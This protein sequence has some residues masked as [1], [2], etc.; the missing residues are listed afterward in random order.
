MTSILTSEG[1]NTLWIGRPSQLNNT[2]FYLVM[3]GLTLLSGGL[4]IP[5]TVPW[6]VYRIFATNNTRYL[7]TDQRLFEERGVFSKHHDDL[8]LY[9]VRDSKVTRPFLNRFFGLSTVEVAT[10][11]LSSPMVRLRGIKDG[12][13]FREMLRVHT[14]RMREKR[15]VRDIDFS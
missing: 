1:E 10:V 13:E 3:G 6:V 12:P 7:L 11:D 8:E 2:G 9:R 14:E 4:L 15:R 5:I